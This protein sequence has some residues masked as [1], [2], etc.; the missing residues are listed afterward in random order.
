MKG[1][2]VSSGMYVVVFEYVNPRGQQRTI[3]HSIGVVQN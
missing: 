3:K 1:Y 2:K